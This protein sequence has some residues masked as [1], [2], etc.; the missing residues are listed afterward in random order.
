ME[1]FIGTVLESNPLK[2]DET[3]AAPRN[4]QERDRI[5]QA[6]V[7]LF[8]TKGYEETTYR[9]IAESCDISRSMVQHYFPKKEQIVTRFFEAHLDDIHA[10]ALKLLKSDADPLSVFCIMGLMHF[11]FLLGN[12]GMTAFTSDIITSR[13]LTESIVASEREWA[14]SKIQ[15]NGDPVTTEDAL[16][17]ALGGAYELLYQAMRSGDSLSPAYVEYAAIVPFAMGMGFSRN[18]VETK[19]KN[20]MTLLSMTL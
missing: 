13:P 15:N 1:W 14:K 3:M 19:L 8:K 17:V 6:A 11:D 20:C 16:T 4:D 9:D 10:Q 18:E 12:K 7:E 2:G 5:Y